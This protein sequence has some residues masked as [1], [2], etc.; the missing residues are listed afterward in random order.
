MA[1]RYVNP[2]DIRWGDT[3]V[4]D[5]EDIIW[6]AT[7]D[8]TLADGPTIVVRVDRADGTEGAE[9]FDA[10]DDTLYTVL[11]A[12]PGGGRILAAA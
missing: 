9:V 1:G 3:L 10:A 12:A 2:R 4:D 6:T 8:A 11:E 5:N 7:W